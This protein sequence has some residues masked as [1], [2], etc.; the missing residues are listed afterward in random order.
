MSDAK[1]WE[2]TPL[3]AERILNKDAKTRGCYWTACCQMAMVDIVRA[4]SLGHARG[5]EAREA[6]G[7][8]AKRCERVIGGRRCDLDAGHDGKHLFWVPPPGCVRYDPNNPVEAE[9]RGRRLEREAVVGWLRANAEKHWPGNSPELSDKWHEGL[10][11]AWLAAASNIA[12]GAHL[13]PDPAKLRKEARDKAEMRAIERYATVAWESSGG[14]REWATA[15]DIAKGAWLG[16]ALAIWQVMSEA[17][18]EIE[19][20]AEVAELAKGHEPSH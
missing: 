11:H 19:I 9:A 17:A 15:T 12:D 1:T 18:R 10:R 14:G 2:P 3:E 4:L 13:A 6:E 5:Y 16:Q 20:D 7:V 8:S